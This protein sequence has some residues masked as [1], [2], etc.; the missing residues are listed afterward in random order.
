ML[1]GL[2]QPIRSNSIA[3]SGRSFRTGAI[4]ATVPTP[5]GARPTC[6]WTT[7]R[8]PRAERDGG[9]AIVPGDLHASELYRRITPKDADERM[10]PA[11]SGKTLSSAEIEKLG[12]WI[13]RERSGSRTGRSFRRQD[14]RLPEFATAG[15]SATRSTRSFWPASKPRGSLLPAKPSAGS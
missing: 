13:A 2:A 15:E 12:R 4:N 8:R 11:K 7:R 14:R 6:G 10:P 9:R 1:T 3:I 5:P